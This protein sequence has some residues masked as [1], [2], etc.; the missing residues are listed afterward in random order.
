[1]AAVNTAKLDQIIHNALS[2]SRRG[3]A[4]RVG[5]TT[6]NIYKDYSR[7]VDAECGH[8]D[9]DAMCPEDWWA[10]YDQDGIAARV[11]EVFP[12][13]C[14]A[15]QP[16]ILEDPDPKVTTPFEQGW[17]NLSKQIQGMK[18]F[19]PEEEN[20]IWDKLLTLD[21]L[22]GI[23][24]FGV[25][26]IGLNDGKPLSEPAEKSDSNTITFLQPLDERHAKVDTFVQD[27]DNVRYGLPELY[28]LSLSDNSGGTSTTQVHWSRVIHFFDSHSSHMVYGV[29][30]IRAVLNRLYGAHKILSGAPEGYWQSAFPQVVFENLPNVGIQE[31][32][33]EEVAAMRERMAEWIAGVQRWIALNGQTANTLEVSISSPTEPLDTIISA[34]C[35]RIKCPKRVFMGSERGELASS[36]DA[37]AWETRLHARRTK[38]LTPRMIAPFVDRCIELGVLPEPTNGFS[39]RW[40]QSEEVNAT[41]RADIA[42]KNTDAMVKYINGGGESLLAPTEFLKHV[43]GFSQTDTEEILKASLAYVG[44]NDDDDQGILLNNERAFGAVSQSGT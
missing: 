40:P 24:S 42:A 30:R 2:T 13:E 22:S 15:V 41:E 10:I 29:P 20:P 39:V 43:L 17:E 23:G 28:K 9:Q 35:I 33:E 25:L 4:R 14:W 11:V 7:N 36:Q 44:D 1:M 18:H 6:K 34:I 38:T 21:I 16:E 3:L 5:G 32:E 12:C 8:P 37:D 26:L 19:R 31:L 27:E